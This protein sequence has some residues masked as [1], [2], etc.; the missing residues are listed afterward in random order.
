MKALQIYT[1][2]KGGAFNAAYNLL[3]LSALINA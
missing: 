3:Y 2:D 1:S